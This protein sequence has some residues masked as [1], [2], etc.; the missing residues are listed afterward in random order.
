MRDYDD[1]GWG[2]GRMGQRS[3][4]GVVSLENFGRQRV[5][6]LGASNCRKDRLVKTGEQSLT[7]DTRRCSFGVETHTRFA[8]SARSGEEGR[9]FRVQLRGVEERSSTVVIPRQ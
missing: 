1:C 9:R 6:V 8:S 7:A 3:D 4:G 5:G 2:S